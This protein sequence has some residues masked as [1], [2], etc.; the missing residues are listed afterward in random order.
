M[1]YGKT[2]SDIAR[3]KKS[4]ISDN[5]KLVEENNRI[6]DI[7]RKQPHREECKVCSSGN[8]SSGEYFCLNKIKYYVCP[9]CGHINGEFLETEDFT[10]SVYVD[11][12]F[13]NF[14]KEDQVE[15]YK[16]RM[17]AIYTPKAKFMTSTLENIC[18]EDWRSFAY[19]DV[20][21]GSG[22]YVAALLELGLDARGIEISPQQ[23][24]F[25]NAMHKKL[26]STV[27]GDKC[28]CLG[29]DEVVARIRKAKEAVIS[30][31]GVWEH[32]INLHE[33]LDAINQNDNIRYV[34]FSVPVFCFSI[35]LAA[36]NED[37]FC[38]S[39]GGAHTHIFTEKSLNYIYDKYKWEIVDQWNFGAD[40]PDLYRILKV[41]LEQQNNNFLS[42]IIDEKIFPLI[43]KMQL[44]IDESG[45]C[46]EVH[47]IIK[48]HKQ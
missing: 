48:N 12:D 7:Y 11:G 18:G 45:M 31:F 9:D 47:V 44:C 19:L 34:Y 1:K 23:V 39:L 4:F 6:S 32:V 33:I 42:R 2:Y 36:V 10:N 13:G 41:K 35:F 26:L 30:F 24:S 43:D 8:Y 3:F 46:S 25:G 16:E 5:K 27:G 15:L 40:I 14:Y 20:G 29:E 37:V 22:Y 38:R 28:F 17:H 21:A